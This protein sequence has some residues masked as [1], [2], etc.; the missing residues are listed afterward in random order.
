MQIPKIFRGRTRGTQ[1]GNIH[2]I[3]EDDPARIV[4]FSDVQGYFGDLTPKDVLRVLYESSLEMFRSLKIVRDKYE[5]FFITPAGEA[6]T[7]YSYAQS[8]DLNSKDTFELIFYPVYYDISSDEVSYGFHPNELAKVRWS[9]DAS[10]TRTLS[11]GATDF[12]TVNGWWP[13]IRAKSGNLFPMAHIAE[14]NVEGK[15]ANIFYD[16]DYELFDYQVNHDAVTTW[17][18]YEDD[19]VI[20]FSKR[21]DLPGYVVKAELSETDQTK[22][23]SGGEEFANLSSKLQPVEELPRLALGCQDDYTP[24]FPHNRVLYH[25]M[26]PWHGIEETNDP[27]LWRINDGDSGTFLLSWDGNW[28]F[29]LMYQQT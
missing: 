11:I 1:K 15:V 3:W 5:T 16:L 27:E 21:G 7:F 29:K 10:P 28:N 12:Y 24:D 14:V 23:M 19:P 25:F 22:V 17:E 9:E 6:F 4:Y 8:H 20:Y 2:D 18:D 13:H 26:T